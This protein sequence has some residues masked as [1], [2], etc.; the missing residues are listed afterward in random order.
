MPNTD[1]RFAFVHGARTRGEAEAYLPS[2]FAV[3]G[4]GAQDGRTFYVIGGY[5]HFGWTLDGYVIPRYASGSIGAVEVSRDEA[6]A[7]AGVQHA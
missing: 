4:E 7:V 3:I 5:D 6:H 1:A 2:G